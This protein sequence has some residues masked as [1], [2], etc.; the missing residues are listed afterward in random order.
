[1]ALEA[2]KFQSLFNYTLIHFLFLFTF[3]NEGFIY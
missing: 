3:E 1:M 2:L